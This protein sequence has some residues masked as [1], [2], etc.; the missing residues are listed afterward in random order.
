MVVQQYTGLL[1]KNAKEIYEGD[2]VRR[3]V[4]HW[5]DGVVALNCLVEFSH[6]HAAFVCIDPEGS[7][8]RMSE[9]DSV[10]EYEV[11]GNMCENQQ[12][13]EDSR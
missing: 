7:P 12:L 4:F 2:I 9:K 6:K 5:G 3:K 10:S 8:L 11:I 13:M 1:D